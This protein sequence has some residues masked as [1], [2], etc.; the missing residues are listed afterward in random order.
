[1]APQ[2]ALAIIAAIPLGLKIP[3][4]YNTS[5]Y[6]SPAALSLMSGL[7]DI[8]LADFKLSSASSSKRLLKAAD[9]PETARE[10]IKIMY[11][12][13]GDLCFTSDGLA[14]SGVLL[15]HLVMPGL[16]DEGR[17]IMAF[18]AS[19]V[20]KDTYVNIMEQY[21]PAAHVGKPSRGKSNELRYADINRPVKD[22]EVNSVRRAAEEAG[23]WRFAEAS[24]HGSFF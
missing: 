11:Q 4:V 5:S 14:K 16:E 21:M 20:S 10:S 8:Y 2:V 7:V 12:Q 22:E 15:R 24:H 18:I 1:M 17:K 9:Y 6:D 19:E 13:V 3:I 23:I